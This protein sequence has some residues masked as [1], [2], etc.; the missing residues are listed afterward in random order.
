MW[1]IRDSDGAETLHSIYP[2]W[3][4]D[5]PHLTVTE[6]VP[7]ALYTAVVEELAEVKKEL[8]TS[9][10]LAKQHMRAMRQRGERMR[11]IEAC[12]NKYYG[13]LQQYNLIG[14]PLDDSPIISEKV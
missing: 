4:K 11:T 2:E 5:L 8:A 14:K 6:L 10:A 7:K 1:V 12:N 3:V 9:Q 13:M